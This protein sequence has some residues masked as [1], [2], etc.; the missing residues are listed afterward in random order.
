MSLAEVR[1][2]IARNVA[3]L[4]TVGPDPA[5]VVAYFKNTFWPWAEALVDE[6]D[7]IDDAVDDLI[8]ES[9]DILQPETASSLSIPLVL[10]TALAAELKKR[11][12]LEP[13]SPAK[14]ELLAKIRAFA[15]GFKEATEIIADI[16][17]A[18]DFEDAPEEGGVDEDDDE[19]DDDDEDDDG[20]EG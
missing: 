7:V 12:D 14:A 8:E 5:S 18:R 16:T 6:L 2:D 9:D 11:V 4:S 13:D 20:E 1:A 15:K 3:A 17:I 19:G 10:G